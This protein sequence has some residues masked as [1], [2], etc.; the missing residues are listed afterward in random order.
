MAEALKHGVIADAGYFELL[1]REFRAVLA[2]DLSLIERVVHRS[3]EIK[4]QVVARDER[5]S[6]VRAVLN[7]GHTVAHAIEAVA[8][9]EASHGEAV[10]VGMAFEAR[11]GEALGV[12]AAGTA[13]RVSRVIERY[14]LPLD[15]PA[16]ATPDELL[17]AMR[18]D[19][20]A[21]DSAIR[22]ALPATIGGMHRTQAGDFT[23]A[24]PEDLVVDTLR[25]PTK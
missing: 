22:F 2:G 17:A 24:V 10:A 6:G 9:F 19:K 3:V 13:A 25:G 14:N 15:L 8:K 4:A 1:E 5:E 23:V 7:F 21:R 20:K 16:A 18:H 11:L 12:T